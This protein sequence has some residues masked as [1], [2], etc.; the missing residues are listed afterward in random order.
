MTYQGARAR[1]HDSESGHFF[2]VSKVRLDGFGHVT[3]VLW[4]EVDTKSNR[5]LTPA[6]LVS[7]AD[8]VDAI[9]AGAQVGA[10]FQGWLPHVPEHTFEVIAHVNGGET[11][12]LAQRSGARSSSQLDLQN[13]ILPEDSPRFSRTA[14]HRLRVHVPHTFAVSKVQLDQDGR[15]TD[16]F[17]GEVDTKNNAWAAPEVLAPVAE[18]VAALQQRDRVFALF[19]SINGHLPDRQFELANYGNGMQTIVLSGPA[20]YDREIHDMDRLRDRLRSA[21]A[22]VSEPAH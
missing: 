22:P 9:H 11:I 2:A 15:V 4:N 10:V 12:A 18:V 20:A 19:P 16:V 5:D 17:W 8:A 3:H 6:A 7:V 1:Q 13:M 14:K 21:P